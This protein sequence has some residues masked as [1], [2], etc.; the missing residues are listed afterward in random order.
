[1]GNQVKEYVKNN[2]EPIVEE[3]PNQTPESD[4]T[5]K[6]LQIAFLGMLRAKGL[7]SEKV[8]NTS[9]DLVMKGGVLNG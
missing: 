2:P 5:D 9:A 3:R 7:I 8:L 1:M 6:D 4:I